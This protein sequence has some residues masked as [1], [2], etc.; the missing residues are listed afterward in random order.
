M[1]ISLKWP[2]TPDQ[3]AGHLEEALESKSFQGRREFARRVSVSSIC[4]PVP[5]HDSGI[6][7]ARGDSR[8]EP[9][10]QRLMLIRKHQ[11][12]SLEDHIF[13]HR[14]ALSLCASVPIRIFADRS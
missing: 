8:P 12:F 14:L 13:R 9:S 10:T 11:M 3:V 7:S 5:H 4:R 1:E 2:V 6:V